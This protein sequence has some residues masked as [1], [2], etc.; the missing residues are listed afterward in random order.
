MTEH[1][2]GAKGLKGAAVM[3]GIAGCL[4]LAAPGG[5]AAQIATYTFNDF[6]GTPFQ[7]GT[8]PAGT[9]VHDTGTGD[10][11]NGTVDTGSQ[12]AVANYR[13]FLQGGASFASTTELSSLVPSAFGKQGSVWS[14]FVFNEAPEGVTWFTI[15]E[16]ATN[17]GLLNQYSGGSFYMRQPDANWAGLVQAFTFTVGHEYDLAGA[18]SDA[19]EAGF[20]Y[21]QLYIRDVTAATGWTTYA[22]NSLTQATGSGWAL[23]LAS[24]GAANYLDEI[25]FYDTYYGTVAGSP[26]ENAEPT[27]VV[28]PEPATTLLLGFGG[29]LAWFG[30]RRQPGRAR[31]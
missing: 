16:P 13:T 31:V 6:T 1:M 15:V 20:T 30:A 4:L 25:R 17:K 27:L 26:F 10:P 28:I 24:M 12:I 5:Y 2:S 21:R 11:S 9:V 19:N 22:G 8:M 23:K 3:G 14:R 18:W 7:N 29:L